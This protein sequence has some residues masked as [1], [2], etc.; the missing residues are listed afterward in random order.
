MCSLKRTIFGSGGSAANETTVD[1]VM[2]ANRN[3]SRKQTNGFAHDETGM[4]LRGQENFFGK[5]KLTEAGLN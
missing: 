3:A 4:M 2:C 1:E 5:K